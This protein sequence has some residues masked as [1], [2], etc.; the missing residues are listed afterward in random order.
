[1]RHFGED[2]KPPTLDM[3]SML[4]GPAA[5]ALYKILNQSSPIKVQAPS[6]RKFW[7]YYYLLAQYIFLI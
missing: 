4:P 6:R 7:I 3:A 5:R 2:P 1:M